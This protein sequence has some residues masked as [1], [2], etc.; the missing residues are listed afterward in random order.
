MRA[1]FFGL[2]I[3]R[4]AKIQRGRPM[5]IRSVRML[6]EEVNVYRMRRSMQ[7]PL[8]IV[9]SQLNAMGKHWRVMAKNVATIWRMLTM[10][11][12]MMR[13]RIPSFWPKSR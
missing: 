8:L 1:I 9:R 5:T 10:L 2:G 13:R 4:L 12:P 11:R 6:K 3:L 7:R